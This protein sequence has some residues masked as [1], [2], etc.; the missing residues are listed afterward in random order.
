M[1]NS[2]EGGF[3]TPETTPT[4]ETKPNEVESKIKE[5]N[6]TKK[7]KAEAILSTNE[8][9][10]ES[11]K[12]ITNNFSDWTENDFEEQ[13][14]AINEALSEIVLVNEEYLESETGKK[15]KE[16]EN[17]LILQKNLIEEEY[18]NSYKEAA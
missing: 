9:R 11:L 13:L 10:L 12:N 18:N 15:L 16:V 1:A 2:F 5:F 7:Q 17:G 8:K 6:E 14:S 4:P 3:P